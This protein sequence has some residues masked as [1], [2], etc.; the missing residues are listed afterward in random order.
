MK[1]A[2]SEN[3]WADYT[4]EALKKDQDQAAAGGGRGF[5]QLKTG[6]NYIRILPAL[7]RD[8][9]PNPW[10]TAMTH[11]VNV[12]P[13]ETVS[14]VCPQKHGGECPNC[15]EAVRRRNAGDSD[16]EYKLKPKLRGYANVIDVGEP[17]KGVQVFGFGTSIYQA[18]VS[19]AEESLDIFGKDTG[20]T[21]VITKEGAGMSTRYS[22]R[23][24]LKA[25]T[26]PLPAA[27]D[28]PDLTKY[29]K[30]LPED[31]LDVLLSSGWKGLA[32]YRQ[33]NR[34][35]AQVPAGRPAA[36]LPRA[37]SGP[38]APSAPAVPVTS[39][40]TTKAATVQ[41]DLDFD[42]DSVLDE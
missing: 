2:E 15:D 9:R 31:E 29:T 38:T 25:E 12:S 40:R 16:G 10:V 14:Y 21:I 36:R 33:A 27:E 41:A 35:E 7:K 26:V 32:K 3:E 39:R 18:L 20:R 24:A 37:T 28:V 8:N 34:V 42:P 23:V 11:M 30:V 4:P 13:T 19:L 6:N 22:V 17:E 1:T 5:L